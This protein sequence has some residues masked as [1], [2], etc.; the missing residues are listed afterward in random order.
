MSRRSVI[1]R[2][3][4]D[5]DSLSIVALRLNADGWLMACEI[6]QQSDRT[7][8][9]RR[10]V[11]NKL[12]WWLTQN[13]HESCGTPELRA[14]FYYLATGHRQ[15]GGRWGNARCAAPLKASSVYTYHGHLSTL[16]SWIVRE[17]NLDVSPMDLIPPPEYQRDDIVPFSADQVQKLVKAAQRSRYPRRDEAIVKLLVD[18]GIRASELCSLKVK[19]INFTE[20]I[21]SVKGKGNKMRVMPIGKQAARAVWAMLQEEPREPDDYLFVG[22]R[23][24]DAGEPI[25]RSGLLQLIERLGKAVNI[26]GVRCSPHTFRH[27]FAIEF[28]RSGGDPFTLMRLLGHTSMTM[29]ERYLAIVKADV[30]RQHREHSPADR[31]FSG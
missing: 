19:H 15:P 24:T 14:Y 29:T 25:T 4:G 10:D 27:T 7:V 8:G 2:S 11:V 21:G 3:T 20:R 13:G 26:Q 18:T 30:V 12:I 5:R 23:G 16:F 9:S 22:E 17:G 28:L 31:L 1:I 6:D